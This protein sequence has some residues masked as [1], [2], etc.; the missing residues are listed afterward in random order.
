MKRQMTIILPE[1]NTKATRKKVE[2]KFEDYRKYLVTLPSDFIPKITPTYS[3]IPPV[4]TNSFHS[5]TEDIAIERIELEKSRNEFMSKIHKAVNTLKN[6]E[7]FIIL[8]KY[9]CH[10]IGY[11]LDIW[12]ELG[13]GKT[14]YYEVKDKAI[15]RLA[16]A[17][18][19]EVYKKK[20]GG[21]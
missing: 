6:D 8:K 21:K 15:L 18:K 20:N 10:D 12:T 3:V 14:K 5:S 11:D 17:L 4:V 16:F 13:I 2:A 19:I 7:R 1:V 9:M